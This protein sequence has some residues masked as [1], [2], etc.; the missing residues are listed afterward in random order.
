MLGLA[1]DA[2]GDMGIDEKREKIRVFWRYEN[3]EKG[4]GGLRHAATMDN[5]IY[6][7]WLRSWERCDTYTRLV[8][9]DDRVVVTGIV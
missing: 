7:L 5:S 3:L 9:D 8:D 2:S 4:F 6:R 1:L